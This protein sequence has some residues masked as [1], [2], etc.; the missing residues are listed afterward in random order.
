MNISWNYPLHPNFALVLLVGPSSMRVISAATQSSPE[1]TGSP[2]T[3]RAWLALD[4]PEANLRLLYCFQ[5]GVVTRTNSTS[6]LNLL[7]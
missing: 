5:K 3:L 2:G 4:Q 7:T 6:Y 1:K